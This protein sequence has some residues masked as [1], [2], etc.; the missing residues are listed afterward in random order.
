[1]QI[2]DVEVLPPSAHPSIQPRPPMP[3]TF[4]LQDPQDDQA[5]GFAT[6]SQIGM[7][8]HCLH[9]QHVYNELIRISYFMPQLPSSSVKQ[10]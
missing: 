10:G 1:M 8:A 7:S 2:A 9:I 5:A 4:V 6:N 3:A